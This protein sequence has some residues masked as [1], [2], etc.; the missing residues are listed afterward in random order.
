MSR[1]RAKRNR[2]R[3]GTCV[4]CLFDSQSLH[5]DQQE[6]RK[7]G[8]R[9]SSVQLPFH[10]DLDGGRKNDDVAQG[11]ISFLKDP[12]PYL[13]T[14]SSTSF[15][16]DVDSPGIVWLVFP[17]IDFN[18]INPCHFMMIQFTLRLITIVWALRSFVRDSQSFSSNQKGSTIY[19][20]YRNRFVEQELVT[21]TLCCK[22][23]R[24][25]RKTTNQISKRLRSAF[26]SFC[27]RNFPHPTKA[28]FSQL[29]RQV[30]SWSDRDRERSMFLRTKSFVILFHVRSEG[31][32]SINLWTLRKSRNECNPHFLFWTEGET[33]V[34]ID[35]PL[36]LL[37]LGWEEVFPDQKDDKSYDW[38]IKKCSFC[39]WN[40]SFLETSSVSYVIH[41][42]RSPMQ[43]R[44]SWKDWA[45][46]TK[47]WQQKQHLQGICKKFDR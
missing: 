39:F 25:I 46:R 27:I 19:I 9:F 22:R 7:E 29:D 23:S 21:T 4:V 14:L 33:R 31:L 40:F 42:P 36:L 30:D 2:Y 32:G 45:T 3:K 26:G 1:L 11:I 35:S 16:L 38:E 24:W 17:G 41:L 12:F 10:L 28:C 15:S 6:T 8:G 37:W 13:I 20:S 43:E 47:M 44:I 18:N 5:E 34:E